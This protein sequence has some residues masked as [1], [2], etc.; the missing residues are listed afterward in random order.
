VSDPDKANLRGW[1]VEGELDPCPF[2]G[3]KSAVLTD[4]KIGVCLQCEALWLKEGE[5]QSL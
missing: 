1:F 3:E 5:P 4:S 2:C